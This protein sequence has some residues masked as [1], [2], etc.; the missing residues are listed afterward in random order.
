MRRILRGIALLSVLLTAGAA[1]A[2]DGL[3][4]DLNTATCRVFDGNGD[5]LAVSGSDVKIALKVKGYPDNPD[6]EAGLAFATCQYEAL[7]PPTE[8]KAEFSSGMDD[9]DCTIIDSSGDPVF[10]ITCQDGVEWENTV[11][12]NGNGKLSCEWHQEALGP[13]CWK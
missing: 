2:N 10:P 4:I 9:R 12:P 8:G 11:G 3:L 6:G 1:A 5:L 7:T 13:G